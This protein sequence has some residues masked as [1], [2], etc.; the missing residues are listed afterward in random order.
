MGGEKFNHL[1][2]SSS[3]V[4]IE[5]DLNQLRRGVF[6]ESSALLIV[7]IFKQ[8]LAEIIAEWI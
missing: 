2:E 3:S 5:G 1:L 8:L 7:R 4:L 6:D